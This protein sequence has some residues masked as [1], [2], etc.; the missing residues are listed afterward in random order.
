MKFSRRSFLVGAGA[1]T[2]TPAIAPPVVF[3][4]PPSPVTIEATA[5]A[6]AGKSL[7]LFVGSKMDDYGVYRWVDNYQ[8]TLKPE[9]FQRI[10]FRGDG[11]GADVYFRAAGSDEAPFM[12][13]DGLTEE[14]FARALATGS[15]VID[16]T[17]QGMLDIGVDILSDSEW[18]GFALKHLEHEVLNTPRPS[19]PFFQKVFSEIESRPDL[20]L[21]P[22][23]HPERV[24]TILEDHERSL[25]LTAE[26]RARLNS[27]W[28]TRTPT[29]A[30]ETAATLEEKP[31]PRISSN[32]TRY[33][34]LNDIAE[35]AER[36][37]VVDHAEEIDHM[38]LVSRGITKTPAPVLARLQA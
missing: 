5:P 32:P 13:A 30:R 22:A 20:L 24:A 28:V 16:I 8:K 23:D 34:L 17:P 33:Q 15:D 1:A 7:R 38:E 9:E 18:R 27:T 4:L 35:T 2:I 26:T 29:P 12:W 31:M 3:E 10:A 25:A 11:S 19:S 14:K 37:S 6:L 21:N 36:R